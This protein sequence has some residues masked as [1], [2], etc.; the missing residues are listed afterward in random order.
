MEQ[1]SVYLDHNATT[2]LAN[3][4][5]AA[6]PQWLESYGNPSSIHWA[7]RPA[8]RIL[9]EARLS[10]AQLLSC[11]P[12]ELIFTGGGSE[13][14]NAVL[15][16]VFDSFETESSSRS[17]VGIDRNELII[18]SIEHPS[19]MKTAE[20]L[21]HKGFRIHIIGVDPKRGV[22]L[23]TYKHVISERT[24]LV[25]IMLANNETGY[26]FPI[27]ELCQIAHQHGALFHTDAVQGLGKIEVDLK[28][29]DVDF[30]SFSAHKFYAL[31]GTGMTFV[32]KGK[33]LESLIH[34]GGQE[35]GR[36]AG[37]ENVLGIASFGLM[38]AKS[39]SLS[40]HIENVRILRDD[41]ERELLA[42]IDGVQIIGG[43][44]PRL[45]NTSSLLIDGI[46]GET[47]LM[48]LDVEGFAVS[49]GAACSSG[50][51]EPSPV[52]LALGLTRKQAQSSLRLSL[53]WH[54]TRSEIDQFIEA[55]K[56]TVKRL[57]SFQKEGIENV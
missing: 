49:T 18:S 2:P 11:D 44:L 25:S 12:L 51:P 34:G 39:A 8:K 30:A 5:K 55:L 46:D 14:N 28:A 50:S 17:T 23:E 19:V 41:L 48:N 24:A 43:E 26:L 32:R 27:R 21:R 31:K 56:I 7:G 45:G 6:I 47:L 3:D 35:R 53:G 15:Q 4:V 54:N 16:G 38:A 13:A 52:L 29:L 10:L 9:R 40:K 1:R 22:D 20:F 42:A 36:R 33:S 57:R 37:T